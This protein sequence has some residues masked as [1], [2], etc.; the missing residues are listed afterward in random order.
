MEPCPELLSGPQQTL[1]IDLIGNAK[2]S[3]GLL[4]PETEE[5]R[6][7]QYIPHGALHTEDFPQNGVHIL[8]MQTSGFLGALLCFTLP[9]EVKHSRILHQL[10][11]P[12]FPVLLAFHPLCPDQLAQ[13]LK[14]IKAQQQAG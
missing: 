12:F 4:S 1:L 7:L 11:L 9:A 13:A 5:S 3:S 6:Q 2:D 8:L 10:F 14:E